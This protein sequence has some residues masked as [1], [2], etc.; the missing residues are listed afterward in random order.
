[1]LNFAC[2]HF[3]M[4]K[5]PT[6][7]YWVSEGLV[8]HV[9]SKLPESNIDAQLRPSLVF[10]PNG[11]EPKDSEESNRSELYI[12]K[13]LSRSIERTEVYIG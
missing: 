12:T 2:C 3:Q 4:A 9:Q 10:I 6:D 7:L 13:K 11:E 1:M 5:N 8:S